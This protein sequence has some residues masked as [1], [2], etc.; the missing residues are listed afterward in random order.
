MIVNAT[1]FRRSLFQTLDGAIRGE[2]ITIVYKGV[3]LVLTT[4]ESQSK[5]ARAVRRDA[6]AVH[7]DQIVASDAELLESLEG[8]WRSE[9]E[10]L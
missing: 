4:K 1:D 6:L 7:P 5:L 10:G 2:P 3:T 8:K 9:D